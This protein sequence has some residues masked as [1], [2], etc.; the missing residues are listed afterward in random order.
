M[1]WCWLFVFLAGC[2]SA[3]PERPEGPGA[4]GE[5]TDEG[6]QL[7]ALRGRLTRLDDELG[8]A[9]AEPKP[10]CERQCALAEQIC[11][12]SEKICSLAQRHADDADHDF[13]ATC[14]DGRAR[15]A[16]D[17]QRVADCACPSP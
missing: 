17:R 4:R 8:S 5:G 2:A 15:C 16:Q 10:R 9:R 1:R 3:Q 6:E 7:E 14:R 12:L 11:E 13:A